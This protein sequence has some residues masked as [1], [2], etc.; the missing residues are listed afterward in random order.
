ML[1]SCITQKQ[2]STNILLSQ[3]PVTNLLILN[4]YKSIQMQVCIMQNVHLHGIDFKICKNA[5]CI[6]LKTVF[7]FV[8]DKNSK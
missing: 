3:V 6:V 1:L 2:G 5:L 4:S 7:A 8:K